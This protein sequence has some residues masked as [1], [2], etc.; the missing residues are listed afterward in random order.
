MHCHITRAMS[1]NHRHMM[2]GHITGL[3]LPCVRLLLNFFP[4]CLTAWGNIN[5]VDRNQP[6][7]SKT[8]ETPRRRMCNAGHVFPIW[9][10]DADTIICD[11]EISVFA[12]ECSPGA[13]PYHVTHIRVRG[14]IN[15]KSVIQVNFWK[16]SIVVGWLCITAQIWNFDWRKKIIHERN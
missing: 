10:P 7:P 15:M 11:G 3:V 6:Q 16:H 1:S 4:K 8:T 9:T 5:L 13:G 2:V 12:Y 14:P